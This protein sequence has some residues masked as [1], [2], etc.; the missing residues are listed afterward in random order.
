MLLR[1]GTGA[2]ALLLAAAPAPAQAP[3]PQAPTDVVARVGAAAV[4]LVDVD[5]RALRIPANRYGELSLAQAVYEARLAALE[6]IIGEHLIA[7][8][9]KVR[10]LDT[11]ALVELEI[12]SKLS[13][14]SDADITA[15]YDANQ[16]RVQGASLEQVR[17]PIRDLLTRDRTADALNRYL[18][19]LK[20]KTPVTITLDPPRVA[21]AEAGRP[22]RGP[23]D[24]P[25]RIIE[26]SDFECPYCLSANPTIAQV[27][28]AYGDRIRLVYRH[29]PLTIHP[30]ARPAAEAAACAAA[31]GQFWPY[32]DRLFADQAQLADADLKRHAA[33]LG[34]DAGAFDACV[35]GRRYRE[36]VDADMAA[37]REAG[38]AGTPA[39][40]IN[41]RLLSGAQPFE[42]FKQII[43]EE[44]A[45]AARAR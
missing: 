27:L 4:L 35:D 21:V 23:E 6:D 33:E 9:A 28:E 32:H 44:L 31:Q 39:F 37:G 12:T 11:D 42:A 30:N 43:D 18:E 15:W 2:L 1:A 38:V 14:P 20:V 34:L 8:E 41:G 19:A 10:G 13:P 25:V 5:A 29:F 36:D 17:E 22:A 3:R 40:F 26:F 24:A 7:V 45:S 16:D